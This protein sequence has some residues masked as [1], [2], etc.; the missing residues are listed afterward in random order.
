MQLALNS[1]LMM[2][3][4]ETQSWF[5]LG[6]TIHVDGKVIGGRSVVDESMLNV[7][8][9]SVFKERGKIGRAHV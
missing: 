2:F 7:E 3:G 4:L 1:P 6:E 5:L 8:S 9:L